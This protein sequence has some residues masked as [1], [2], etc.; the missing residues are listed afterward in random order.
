MKN[1]TVVWISIT[2]ILAIAVLAL[3]AAVVRLYQQQGSVP[4]AGTVVSAV[5]NPDG[6]ASA[7]ASETAASVPGIT[8][9]TALQCSVEQGALRLEAGD[10]FGLSDTGSSDCQVR[11][12]DGVYFLSV[13]TTQDAPIV[14]TFP[15]GTQ[16]DSV[17]LTVS[18]GTL[19]ADGLCAQTLS[20]SCQQGTLQY[21]GQVLSSAEV[22][23]LQGETTLQ[24]E[25]SVSDFNYDLT[26]DLGH[27]AIG[28]QSFAGARGSRTIDN[29]SAKN[30]RV[31]CSMG[32]VAVLF[33]EA[34]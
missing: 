2:A 12:E 7:A 32:S 31:H 26:Y 34:S 10:T 9:P 18:G 27:I 4:E 5:S 14:L 15:R 3:G 22:E 13:R 11:W 24:L 29:G 28:S 1:F 33:P 6:P 23:H 8:V 30:I 17:S 25:G 21:A 16:F 20:A 19:S